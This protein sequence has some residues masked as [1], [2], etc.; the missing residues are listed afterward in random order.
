MKIT[1][2]VIKT[3]EIFIK[4]IEIGEKVVKTPL[5]LMKV[6]FINTVNI[7]KITI[8]VAKNFLKSKSLLKFH[9]YD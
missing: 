7:L 6:L 2:T 9:K 8:E 4:I 3:V 5:K 1:I